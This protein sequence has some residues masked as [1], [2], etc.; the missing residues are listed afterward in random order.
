MGLGDMLKF[1]HFRVILAPLVL[2][3][4]LYLNLGRSLYSVTH[5]NI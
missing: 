4:R 1:H 2:L 5:T 3:K